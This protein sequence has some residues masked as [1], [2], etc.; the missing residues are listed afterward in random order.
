VRKVLG[1]SLIF[2]TALTTCRGGGPPVRPLLA[3]DH[4]RLIALMAGV[5]SHLLEIQRGA[6]DPIEPEYIRKHLAGMRDNFERACA[7][8][9]PHETFRPRAREAIDAVRELEQKAWTTATRDDGYATL[10]SL[11]AGCHRVF[12]PPGS[13]DIKK[14]DSK[15][16]CAQC[17]AKIFD[18]WKETLHARAWIDPVY[19]LSAGNPPKMECRGCHSM[20]PILEREIST[21]VTYRPV[22]R[23]YNHD[24]GI[25]CITCH[26]LADGSMAA[27]RDVPGAPCRPRRDDRLRTPEFCG[28]CHNPTHL[29]YDEWKLSKSGKSC[30][31]C[32]A[33]KNG[34]F[35]HKMMSVEDPEFVKSGLSWSCEVAGGALKV[36]LTNRSGHRLPAEVP[37]RLLR[38]K[39]RIGEGEEEVVLR[40]PMKAHIGEKDNRLWPDETR[41]L[42]RPAPAGKA[43]QVEILYQQG[44][45]SQPHQWIVIGKWE[46]PP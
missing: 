44:P 25:G 19:R 26:G 33:M 35:S 15:Q 39:I 36:S 1:A 27:A 40:R 31:D 2:F 23:P 14:P 28:A 29:V 32:H 8:Q 17:H 5:D 10:K 24:D 4:D 12:A 22:Y 42:A 46:Q 16:A 41:V 37:T 34:K 38:I 13:V 30:V 20:E 11:C 3:D 9:V 18:E 21:D 43:V 45:F 6:G 7:L